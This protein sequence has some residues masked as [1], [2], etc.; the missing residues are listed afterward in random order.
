[1]RILLALLVAVVTGV[2]WE[3]LM[4][5]ARRPHEP[6]FGG[7]LPNLDLPQPREIWAGEGGFVII[8]EPVCPG[9]GVSYRTSSGHHCTRSTR[10]FL[11]HYCKV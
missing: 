4:A 2:L 1:M 9:H 3:K 10:G 6:P 7:D 8:R 11:K 5:R